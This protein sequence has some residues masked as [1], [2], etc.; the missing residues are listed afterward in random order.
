MTAASNPVD[1]GIAFRA[2]MY[3]ACKTLF[4]PEAEHLV[5]TRTFPSAATEDMVLI[6]SLDGLRDRGDDPRSSSLRTQDWDLSLDIHTY[7]FRAGGG[8]TEQ[9]ADD[10]AYEAAGGY[11][12]RIAEYVRRSSPNGDTTLGGK[13]M[14]SGLESFTTEPGRVT[15]AQGTGRMWEFI[16][17]FV[18]RS[19]VT[20]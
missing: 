19:R 5:V 8:D 18:A 13:V 10:Q 16:G 7:A 4:T 20:G 14:W 17:T 15:A 9:D 12:N 3:V 11:L 6:G 1:A 2:A